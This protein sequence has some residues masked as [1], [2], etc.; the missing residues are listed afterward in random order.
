MDRLNLPC[1]EKREFDNDKQIGSKKRISSRCDRSAESKKRIL[2]PSSQ[3]SI[4]YFHF[5]S[6]EEYEVTA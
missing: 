3:P 5:D 1:T 4:L 2:P 6:P